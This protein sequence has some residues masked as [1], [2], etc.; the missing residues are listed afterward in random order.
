[1]VR[2]VDIWDI[3]DVEPVVVE[4]RFILVMVWSMYS[5]LVVMLAN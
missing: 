2:S 1:M 5:F 4:R 3:D